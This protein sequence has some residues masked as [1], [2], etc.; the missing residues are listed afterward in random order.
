MNEIA[1]VDENNSL[2]TIVMAV[3][4][5]NPRWLSEQLQ[6]LNRQTYSNIKLIVCDDCPDEPADSALFERYL[7][8][9]PFRIIRNTENIGSNRTFERLTTEAEG[10]YIAYCDQ[11][12]IWEA[13]KIELLVR[14]IERTGALL[15]FSDLSVIDEDGSKMAESITKIRKR[16]VFKEGNNLAG[17]L[18][19]RN[20]IVGCA[21]LIRADVAKAAMPFEEYMVHD[22]WLALYTAVNGQLAYEPTAT[23][24]YRQHGGNQTL[25]LTGIRTKDDYYRLRIEPMYKR[26]QSLKSRFA[27]NAEMMWL[28]EKVSDWA[29]ARNEYFESPSLQTAKHLWANRN[30]ERKFTFFELTIILIPGF[31]FGTVVSLFR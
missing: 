1:H 24:R 17:D 15:C 23:V 31:L 27:S 20:F 4:K 16:H 25:V 7:T 3:Y 10:K 18:V 14:R 21:M 12:D 29:I 30:I 28:L 11:D 26:I 19:V 22:H 6:S 2:V 13:N 8:N 9:F 5:P